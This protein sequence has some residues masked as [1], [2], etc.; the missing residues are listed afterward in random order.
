MSGSKEVLGRTEQE[1]QERREQ[2]ELA[3]A[4][5]SPSAQAWFAQAV[6]LAG[7][8][9]RS[10]LSLDDPLLA[11]VTE[12]V[13]DIAAEI[14]RTFPSGIL[15]EIGRGSAPG[16]PLYLWVNWKVWQ[17]HMIIVGRPELAE[18]IFDAFSSTPSL[19]RFV[20]ARA[21]ALP[22]TEGIWRELGRAPRRGR[23][24]R[25]GVKIGSFARREEVL[26]ALDERAD[27]I[28]TYR[29]GSLTQESL[30]EALGLDD[31]RDLL[32]R[33]QRGRPPKR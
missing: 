24:R 15:D 28:E 22:Q 19:R 18:R 30:A 6:A 33:A 26:A 3:W 25:R 20:W 21:D 10:P 32:W 13:G 5:L 31:A 27:W 16:E 4:R 29:P 8:I 14:E 7:D 11:A 2:V 17:A 1:W 23:P 12:R 9:A